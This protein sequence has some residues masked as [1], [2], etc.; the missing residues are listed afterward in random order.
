LTAEQGAT[1]T[2]AVERIADSLPFEDQDG[3]TSRYQRRADALV[4]LAGTHIAQDQDPD[5]ATVIV[6]T[7]LDTLRGGP[8]VGETEDGAVFSSDV[9]RRLVC[10]SRIQLL[11]EDADGTPLGYG[12]TRRTAPPS[13]RRVL[14][15]RD[16]V[17]CW[18]GCGRSDFL[19]SHHR[20]LWPDGGRTNA[21][22]MEM[23]CPVHHAYIHDHDIRIQGAPGGELRFFRPDG[24]EIV[25]GLPPLEPQVKEWFDAKVSG[26]LVPV[27]EPEE[28][29]VPVRVG[30]AWDTS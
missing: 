3:P 11:I 24:S 17:C 23:F 28:E 21:S 27:S 12:R 30:A 9:M 16:R 4:Q 29:R 6:H 14:K 25:A 22:E 26:P 2:K 10:D 1:F 13:L 5:R 19:Q 7:Y 20:T 15:E 8:G 18:P